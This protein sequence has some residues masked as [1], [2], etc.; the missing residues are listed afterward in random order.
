MG[1]EW[2]RR[3]P[4]APE[5]K[6]KK[7]ETAAAAEVNKPVEVHQTTT[8]STTSSAHL[9]CRLRRSSTTETKITSINELV[10]CFRFC[11][12]SNL[13]RVAAWEADPFRR[14]SLVDRFD[15]EMQPFHER[16]SEEEKEQQDNPKGLFFLFLYF[17][18]KWK[19]KVK[20]QKCR[21]ST[22]LWNFF[23]LFHRKFGSFCGVWNVFWNVKLEFLDLLLSFGTTF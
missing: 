20:T 1:K 8:S 17:F 16:T 11:F 9:R 19:T 15:L 21:F 23:G 22:C 3:P 4:V 18:F 10:S 2:R 13:R 12:V 7:K 14:F 5:K 6:R